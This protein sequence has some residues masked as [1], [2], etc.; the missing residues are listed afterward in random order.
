MVGAW[1]S[2]IQT[3]ETA[4]LATVQIISAIYIEPWQEFLLLL[5]CPKKK[6]V[7]K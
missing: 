4:I 7:V 2:S 3:F 6:L 5:D 1:Q